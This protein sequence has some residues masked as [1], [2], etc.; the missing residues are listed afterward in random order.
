MFTK[1][2]NSIRDSITR[3]PNQVTGNDT[4]QENNS[5]PDFHRRPSVAEEIQ[6]NDTHS[7]FSSGSQSLPSDQLGRNHSI[8]V[9]KP[10][11]IN[12]NKMGGKPRRESTLFGISNVTADDYVQKD[13]ISNSWS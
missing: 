3:G 7:V 8:S 6:N 13:L 5:S 4:V 2:F 9:S 12:D 11:A 10:I 1:L